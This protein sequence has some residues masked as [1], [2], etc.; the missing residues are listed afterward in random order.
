[1]KKRHLRTFEWL[2]MDWR[3]FC[4]H[5]TPRWKQMGGPNLWVFK[6]RRVGGRYVGGGLAESRDP[7]AGAR[8][9]AAVV[10]AKNG[11]ESNVPYVWVYP[12]GFLRDGHHP[13]TRMKV[14]RQKEKRKGVM[15]IGK[16]G[17]DW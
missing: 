1:M 14:T 5:H 8:H 15:I 4:C 16:L 12:N 9:L 10:S 6:L 11:R 17:S 3:G 7:R 2:K 13:E